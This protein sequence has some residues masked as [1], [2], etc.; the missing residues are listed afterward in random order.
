[1]SKAKAKTASKNNP[2]SREQA[3]E[4][5]HNGQKIKPV[6]L[7]S[8]QNS[9]MAAEYESSGD[10]VVGSNNQPLPW[11]LVKNLS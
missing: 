10:L 4:Y 11:G 5:L 1:M 7:I 9:F 6:K 2:T 3:K 8:A